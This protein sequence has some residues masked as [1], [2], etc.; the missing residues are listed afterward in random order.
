MKLQNI[1]KDNIESIM[2]AKFDRPILAFHGTSSRYLDTIL[3]QG[4]V[5][6]KNDG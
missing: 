1:F 2:E 3:S 5:P 6:Q 4:L